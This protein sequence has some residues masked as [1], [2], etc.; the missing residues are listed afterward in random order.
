MLFLAV[1]CGFQAENLREHVVERQREKQYIISL[2]RDIA[3][4]TTQVDNW[5]VQYHELLRNCDTVLNYFSSAE[6][7][8]DPWARNMHAIL[9]GYP[10]FI[11][12]DQTMDELKNAGGLRLI[13]STN[14]KDS[15]EAYDQAVRDLLIEQTVNDGYF[16]HITN[17][18]NEQFSYKNMVEAGN[19][20]DAS[21]KNHW[22]KYDPLRMEQLYN[23]VY[24]YH[25]EMSDFVLY[26]HQLKERGT[27]LILQLKDSY[28]LK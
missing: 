24:K 28:R 5:T 26:M 13:R 17:F 3:T 21:P 12:T 6:K 4:D 19:N 23:L 18:S 25:D 10:D 2:I 1:F 7:Y 27:R 11:Y 16:G 15:I 14:A 9:H 20:L 8:S 22:I